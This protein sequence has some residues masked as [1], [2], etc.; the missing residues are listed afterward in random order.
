MN[1]TRESI[2]MHCS[3][4]AVPASTEKNVWDV[5]LSLQAPMGNVTGRHGSH[6][7]PPS[8][9]SSSQLLPLLCLFLQLSLAAVCRSRP[10][11]ELST[12]NGRATWKGTAKEDAREGG[13]DLDS[14][15]TSI[16]VAR[17]PTIEVQREYVNNYDDILQLQLIF[18]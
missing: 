17:Q 12:M 4:K 15:F 1:I 8:I 13:A 7:P 6:L 14:M 3:G 2:N 11:S 16:S 10:E 5:V 9:L 18:S